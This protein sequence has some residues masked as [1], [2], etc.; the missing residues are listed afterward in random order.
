MPS[1]F[2]LDYTRFFPQFSG[3][4]HKV[5]LFHRAR[6]ELL[7][8]FPMCHVVFCYDEAAACFF[9]ETMNDARPFLSTDAR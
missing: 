8:Q 1:N 2:V 6:R 4:Q 9:I 5:N 7:R 3:Y